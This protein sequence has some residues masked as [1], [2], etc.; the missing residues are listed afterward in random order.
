MH[1]LTNL[2]KSKGATFV[3]R[4]IDR[5]LLDI[6]EALRHEFKA[7]V[8]V[9]ATGLQGKTLA[10]DNSCY[11]IRGGLIRVIND[12][13][14]FPKVNAALTITADAVH[15]SSEIIFLVPRNGM[16]RREDREILLI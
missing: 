9:N 14:N 15:D 1:W 6:E 3:M 11:P 12:G 10:G 2:V 16:Y 13:K 5:D 4:T 8:I 7:D